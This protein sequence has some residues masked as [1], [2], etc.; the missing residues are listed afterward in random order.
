MKKILYTLLPQWADWEF[1]YLSSAA[2]M[3]GN[4]KF[5]NKILSLPPNPSFP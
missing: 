1:A 3:L 4:G 5:E 2:S